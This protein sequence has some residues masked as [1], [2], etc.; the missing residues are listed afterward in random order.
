MLKYVEYGKT[1]E[2]IYGNI[3]I[4]GGGK[5]QLA[6]LK[7]QN[8]IILM[9]FQADPSKMVQIPLSLMFWDVTE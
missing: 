5:S 6:I 9:V 4:R 7:G 1:C 2:E 3:C 8:P